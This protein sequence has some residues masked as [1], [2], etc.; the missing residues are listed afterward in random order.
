MRLGDTRLLS[1]NGRVGMKGKLD[2]AEGFR[3]HL[4]RTLKEPRG[5]R[6]RAKQLQFERTAA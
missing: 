5:S 6:N 2:K 4:R 3:L 1:D